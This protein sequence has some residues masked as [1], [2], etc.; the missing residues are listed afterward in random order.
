MGLINALDVILL[1]TAAVGYQAVP[2]DWIDR[3]EAQV[4]HAV[5][6]QGVNGLPLEQDAK[7]TGNAVLILE[8]RFAN[9]RHRLTDPNHAG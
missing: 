5:K 1:Y 3:L 8:D 7:G 2:G 4:M 9:L 6:N